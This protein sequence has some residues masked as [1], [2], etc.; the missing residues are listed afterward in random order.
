MYE[1]IKVPGLYAIFSKVSC[2]PGGVQSSTRLA[3][4]DMVF[5]DFNE[6]ELVN[7][8][9]NILPCDQRRH[10]GHLLQN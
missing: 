6:D 9:N 5:V 1:A 2:N 7:D 4:N 3:N 8:C 10:D